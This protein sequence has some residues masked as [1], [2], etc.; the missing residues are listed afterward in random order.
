MAHVSSKPYSEPN[1][2]GWSGLSCNSVGGVK[3]SIVAFQAIDPGSIPGWRSFFTSA[4]EVYVKC[5]LNFAMTL[6]SAIEGKTVRFYHSSSEPQVRST[7]CTVRE[8]LPS[9][10]PSWAIA[11][12]LSDSGTST[13][14]LSHINIILSPISCIRVGGVKVSIVAFQAIDPGS[15]PGWR[16]VFKQIVKYE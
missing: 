9:A 4:S 2:I 6:R 10:F 7:H 15:I 8:L 14:E 13:C 16:S 12:L 3:V 11:F 5:Y 1:K